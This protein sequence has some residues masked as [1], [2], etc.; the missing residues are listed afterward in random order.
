MVKIYLSPSTQPRNIYWDKKHNEEQVMNWVTD[1]LVNFLR[2]YDVEVIRGAKDVPTTERI[3]RAN[4]LK[5]DYYL[6]IHS[7]AAGGRGCETFYQVG[8][9]HTAV[10]K[11]RSKDYAHRLNTDLAKITTTNTNVG[12]RG[13]KFK[14]LTNGRDGNHELRGVLF[15]ANLVEVEFHDTEAGHRWILDNLQLI[16]ETMAK[17]MVDMFNLKLKP[18]A[19]I[20]PADEFFF[21]QT[22]AYKTLAEAEVEAKKVATLTK[23]EVG[24][25]YGSKHALRWVKGIK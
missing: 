20:I 25:K 17:S 23:Q 1:H 10:V 7:N 9:N 4:S 18:V 22:G 5:V 19:P 12:D 11:A 14:T 3:K 8:S 16:G 21:V 13:I 15:P 24:I 2:K 6:S